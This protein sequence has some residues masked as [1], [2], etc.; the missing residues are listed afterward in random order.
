[1]LEGDLHVRWET[2]YLPIVRP[3]HFA[4]IGW[5]TWV[6]PYDD[7]TPVKVRVRFVD[8]PSAWTFASS[9]GLDRRAVAF[10]GKLAHFRESLFVGGDFRLLTRD[11]RGS[12]VFVAVR[13]RWPFGDDALADRARKIVDGARTFWRDDAQPDFLITLMPIAGPPEAMSRGGTGLWHSFAAWSTT[14]DSL[15][16]LDA[17]FT[18]EYFHHWNPGALGTPIEPEALA[19]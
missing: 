14:I 6:V 2:T 17:L 19:Y 12:R 1:M 10:D 18:H 8:L 4:W 13:G 15:D 7:D 16:A 5:T 9:F 11:V 3:D